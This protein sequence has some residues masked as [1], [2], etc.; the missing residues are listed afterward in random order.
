MKTDETKIING[1]IFYRWKNPDGT[2]GGWVSGDARVYGNAQVYGNAR[3]YGNAW[4]YG[5]AWDKSPLYIQ[6]SVHA[7]TNYKQ[8][9]IK[10]GCE[11]HTFSEWLINY[12]AIGKEHNYTDSEIA[13]YKK[14]IDLFVAIGR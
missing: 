14:I 2:L 4:V 3:V 11:E 12:E 6:G 1:E 13:E 7:A 5:D 9:H 8:G 10:I